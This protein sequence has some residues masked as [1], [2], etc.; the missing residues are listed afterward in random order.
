MVM[1]ELIVISEFEKITYHSF[2]LFW[3]RNAHA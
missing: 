1:D 2:I 3:L